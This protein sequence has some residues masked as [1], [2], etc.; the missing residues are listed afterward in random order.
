LIKNNL[1]KLG[2]F[3]YFFSVLIFLILITSLII[4]RICAYFQ[5]NK[6]EYFSLNDIGKIINFLI[7]GFT[8]LDIA[9][10]EG[11]PL[12]VTIALA[13]SIKK[14]LNDNNFVRHLQACETMGFIIS[15]ILYFFFLI[16]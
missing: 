10:P 7:I 2:K 5:S 11:L 4:S 9:I 1:K 6:Q 3:G 15:L 8:V 14:M 13:Y 12:C 16:F